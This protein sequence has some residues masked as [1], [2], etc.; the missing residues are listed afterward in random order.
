ML[1]LM[2]AGEMC[3]WAWEATSQGE[4]KSEPCSARTNHKSSTVSSGESLPGDSLGFSSGE[5]ISKDL[6][7]CVEDCG[8]EHGS[9]SNSTSEEGQ[10]V[11]VDQISEGSRTEENGSTGLLGEAQPGDTG[12]LGDADATSE[13]G[14]SGV[15]AKNVSEDLL[16]NEKRR[17]DESDLYNVM[18]HTHGQLVVDS[19]KRDFDPL[20]HG[21]EMLSKY[22]SVAR[23]PLKKHGWNYS[24]AVEI[25]VKLKKANLQRN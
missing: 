6:K 1:S 20:K 16:V 19:W 13:A 3:Y 22:I 25:M 9:A 10:F 11:S 18:L 4:D 15:E 17:S 12:I 23:G 2:Y 24:K 7:M 14:M 8:R 5:Q 21:V